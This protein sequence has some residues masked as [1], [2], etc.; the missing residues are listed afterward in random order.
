MMTASGDR[1]IGDRVMFKSAISERR[2]GPTDR[3]I[4][5]STIG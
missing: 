1:A 4:G 3:V 5:R 2:I